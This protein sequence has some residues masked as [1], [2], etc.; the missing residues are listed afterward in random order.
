MHRFATLRMMHER[1]D[2][3]KSLVEGWL[4]DIE[5]IQMFAF[6]SSSRNFRTVNDK[7]KGQRTRTKPTGW[8][9]MDDSHSRAQSGP[10]GTN[11]QTVKGMSRDLNIHLN[12]WGWHDEKLSIFSSL[13]KPEQEEYAGMICIFHDPVMGGIKWTWSFTWRNRAKLEFCPIL[14]SWCNEKPNVMCGKMSN[15][16]SIEL[17]EIIVGIQ[18]NSLYI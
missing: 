14:E 1:G 2:S 6:V 12:Q 7:R 4:S 10:N 15:A 16:Q 11:L 13:N 18:T 8:W 17:A 9:R 3:R 5:R